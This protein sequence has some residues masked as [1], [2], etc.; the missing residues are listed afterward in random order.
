MSIISII[1]YPNPLLKSTCEP[2]ASEL[3]TLPVLIKDLQDTLQ[4]HPYCV[5]LAASQIGVLYRVIAIDCSRSRKPCKNHGPLVL[6]N[7]VI[8]HTAGEQVMREG[9]L[10]LPDYTGNVKRYQEI[11]VEAIDSEEI[12]T[13]IIAV[14]FEA[15]VLQ[16][17]I[18]H[19]DGVLFLDRVS[20]LKTDVF[21]RKSY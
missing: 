2:I 18:D 8:T 7:P 21:R 12:P 1:Q 4:A 17:E 6:I 3:P 19:L 15:V 14:G 10:S 16:H 13:K 9:C 5:G 20:S 11:T